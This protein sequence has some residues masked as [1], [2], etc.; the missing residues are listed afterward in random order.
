MGVC[1][2]L[3]FRIWNGAEVILTGVNGFIELISNFSEKD[4][5][6]AIIIY[7]GVSMVREEVKKFW[8]TIEKYKTGKLWE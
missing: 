2:H 8:N 4:L 3:L 1:D 6:E 7:N 5:K